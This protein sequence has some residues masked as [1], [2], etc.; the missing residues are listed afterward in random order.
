MRGGVV[1]SANGL[2]L[3]SH[4]LFGPTLVERRRALPLSRAADPQPS[5]SEHHIRLSNP[6]CC[7]RPPLLYLKKDFSQGYGPQ[8]PSRA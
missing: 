1:V 8:I 5:Q 7:W 6:Y 2:G 4:T 3:T